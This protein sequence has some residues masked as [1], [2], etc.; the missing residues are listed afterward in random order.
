MSRKFILFFLISMGILFI[1]AAVFAPLW[2]E[3]QFRKAEAR[4]REV[5]TE[6]IQNEPELKGCKVEDLKVV[7]GKYIEHREN[8]LLRPSEKSRELLKKAVFVEPKNSV[9]STIVAMGLLSFIFFVSAI[10][11]GIYS[12]PSGRVRCHYGDHY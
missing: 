11:F 10:A 8:I 2:A 12:N 5:L 1:M 4:E 7:D 9:P 6:I 3:N